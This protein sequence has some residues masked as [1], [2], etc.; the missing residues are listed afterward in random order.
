MQRQE[1]SPQQRQVE[2][3]LKQSD[4]AGCLLSPEVYQVMPT[5]QKQYP[6]FLPQ[7][8]TLNCGPFVAW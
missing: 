1:N 3:F 5:L 2:I 4:F 7:Q 8:A 6:N